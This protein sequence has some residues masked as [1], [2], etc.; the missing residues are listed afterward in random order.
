MAIWRRAAVLSAADG[1]S[2]R[3]NVAGVLTCGVR[4]SRTVPLL[5]PAAGGGAAGAG[6]GGGGLA[7]P[8]QEAS[9]VIGSL[10]SL[11]RQAVAAPIV[12]SMTPLPFEQLRAL[13]SSTRRSS[14][15]LTRVSSTRHRRA[16]GH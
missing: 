4:L 15:S 2:E 5:P 13:R 8:P 16:C 12:K 9:R 1:D 3:K 6:G 7:P 10:T 14:A 11:I